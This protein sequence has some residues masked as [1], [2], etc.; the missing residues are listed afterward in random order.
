MDLRLHTGASVASERA[1]EQW[2]LYEQLLGLPTDVRAKL[3][4]GL[5][6]D[7]AER[8]RRTAALV[9]WP[10]LSE[11][12]Y[13]I[14]RMPQN[15]ARVTRVLEFI[16]DG[17]RIFDVGCGTGML[18][19]QILRHRE[20]DAYFGVDPSSNLEATMHSMAATNDIDLARCT[21]VEGT[22]QEVRLPD[23]AAFRP[24][25]ALVLEMLEHVGDPFSVLGHV[26]RLVGP[27]ADI[28]FS[29]PLLGRI[30][31][32]WGHLSVFDRARI[33][34][35]VA[36]VD[37]EISWLEPVAGEWLLVFLPGAGSTRRCEPPGERIASAAAEDDYT[38]RK[39]DVSSSQLAA[40]S[41]WLSDRSAAIVEQGASGISISASLDS[42]YMGLSFIVPDAEIVRLKAELT[43]DEPEMVFGE[44]RSSSEMVERW[45]LTDKEISNLAS[46]K[47]L[48]F[49]RG[50]AAGRNRRDGE[51]PEAPTTRFDL[52]MKGSGESHLTVTTFQYVRRFSPRVPLVVDLGARH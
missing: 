47:T 37:R 26:A 30:E 21:F 50:L 10:E 25:L 19:G 7:L 42:Q 11:A 52:A 29:V 4:A 17:E 45:Y 14:Y 36:H 39:V 8:S 41:T 9:R 51:H 32:E 34:R 5:H 18:T 16:K 28:L 46:G 2:R 35:L 15:I 13:S 40:P 24:T 1:G 23:V 49:H 6:H 43:V 20:I 12:A 27:E 3:E 22:V 48:V 38:F 33:E 44:F 31:H